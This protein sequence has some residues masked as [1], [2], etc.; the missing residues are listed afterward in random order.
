V[1]VAVNGLQ[2]GK[3]GSPTR[4]ECHTDSRSME[5]LA[6]QAQAEFFPHGG[7]GVRRARIPGIQRGP[8]VSGGV[9]RVAKPTATHFTRARG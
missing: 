5:A 9:E 1:A 3:G 4:R 7:T 2:E 8:A 6:G